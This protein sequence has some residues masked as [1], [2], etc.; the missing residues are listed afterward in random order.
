[1][2]V[3]SYLAPL[4]RASNLQAF[5]HLLIS[6]PRCLRVRRAIHSYSRHQSLNAFPG[7][8]VMVL[9]CGVFLLR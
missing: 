1:M 7:V 2:M 5:N 9:E 4:A 3:A 8:T 6:K